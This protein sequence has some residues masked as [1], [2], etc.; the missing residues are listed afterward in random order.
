MLMLMSPE[1]ALKTLAPEYKQVES[2]MER[3]FWNSRYAK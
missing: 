2:E 1:E 3:C